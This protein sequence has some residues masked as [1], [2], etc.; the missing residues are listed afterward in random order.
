MN[1]LLFWV[2]SS[3]QVVKIDN[4]I[5]NLKFSYTFLL[6][7]SLFGKVKRGKFDFFHSFILYTT[8]L[9]LIGF[10]KSTLLLILIEVGRG[11][12]SEYFKWGNIVLKLMYC[13]KY[14]W[15]SN[16]RIHSISWFSFFE[17]ENQIPPP[18]KCYILVYASNK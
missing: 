15:F 6:Y 3:N 13:A 4:I 18:T 9:K 8:L 17:T 10:K 5:I 14:M 12:V 16:F 1:F 7:I 11:L 2:H